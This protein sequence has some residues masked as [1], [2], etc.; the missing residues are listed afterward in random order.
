MPAPEDP[1]RPPLL[2]PSRAL[3]S[4]TAGLLL[5]VDSRGSRHG[6]ACHLPHTPHGAL[7]GLSRQIGSLPQSLAG[8]RGPFA[9]SSPG[10]PCGP[11]SLG[12]LP[13][14]RPAPT[15]HF[16][17]RPRAVTGQRSPTST[18][19][20]GHVSQAEVGVSVQSPEPGLAGPTPSRLGG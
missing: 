10:L 11:L 5:P 9:S 6:D 8:V 4:V 20:P 7:E 3:A 2:T 16:A 17:P 13:H 18:L 14:P 19:I 12:G 1:G 15:F